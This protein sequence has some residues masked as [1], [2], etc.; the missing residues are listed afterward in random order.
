M[1]GATTLKALLAAL[2]LPIVAG[3][4]ARP[5][6]VWIRLDIYPCSNGDVRIEADLGAVAEFH[7]HH[8]L[9]APA[10]QV[11]GHGAGF[12]AVAGKP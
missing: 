6:S 8:Q 3:L 12:F 1:T 7:A 4:G 5:R 11:K 10:P 9:A 2:G